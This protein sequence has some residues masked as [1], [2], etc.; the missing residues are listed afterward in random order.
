[1]ATTPRNALPWLL[2]SLLVL[3]LD[4]WSKAVA[5]DALELHEPVAVIDGWLNWTLTYNYGAAFSFLSDAGGWQRWLFSVL[6]A[7]VS[8]VLALWLARL[9]RHDWRQALPFALIIGGAIG[10]LVDRVRFGYVVDFVDAYWREH[11]WPAFNI[12]DSALV[13]GAIAMVLF[14]VV[15]PQ[16]RAGAR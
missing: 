16:R 13:C 7:A 4:Q 5:L 14:T 3:V 9:P 6:A 12:A 15:M 1:M 8:V 2:L 11:H 10:N